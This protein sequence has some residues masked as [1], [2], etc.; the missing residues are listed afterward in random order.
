MPS[1]K[2]AV[3]PST[4]LQPLAGPLEAKSPLGRPSG[5]VVKVRLSRESPQHNVDGKHSYRLKCFSGPWVSLGM[6]GVV[7]KYPFEDP[8]NALTHGLSKE[9]L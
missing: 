4:L 7:P 9:D 3:P 6:D 1:L 8:E 2:W 5:G